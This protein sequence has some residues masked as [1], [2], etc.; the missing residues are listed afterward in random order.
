MK[1]GIVGFGYVGS[2]VAASYAENQVKVYDPKY[3]GLSRPLMEIKNTSDVIFVCVPTPSGPEGCDTSILDKVVT[4]LSGYTGLVIV[5]STAPPQWYAEAEATSG[6]NISH[7]P[8][9]LTQAR[10]K[11]DYVNPHKIVVGCKPELRDAVTKALLASAINFDRI[12]NIEFCSIAEASFFKYMA[13]NML[14]MKVVI[15]NEMS[16]LA[17]AMGLDWETVSLM[18]KSDSRLGNTHWAVPGPD[19]EYGFGGACFPKDTEALQ[20]MAKELSVEMTMLDTA[21]KTNQALRSDIKTN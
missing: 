6:L 20:V 3:P 21:I 13:N 16:Q 14:A 12:H 15:N 5:K 19:G 2:A 9:F 18:A 7:V 1:I 17:N 4:D 10:A 11:Y 8:E